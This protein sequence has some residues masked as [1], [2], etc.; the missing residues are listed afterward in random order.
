MLE[1]PAFLRTQEDFEV[2]VAEGFKGLSTVEKGRRFAAFASK[3]IA[4]LPEF[5]DFGEVRLSEKE[6]HD[7]G[8]DIESDLLEDGRRL[9]VQSK[10]RIAGKDD[11]DGIISKFHDFEA[12]ISKGPDQR[13]LFE[14]V[15]NRSLPVFGIVTLPR[16]DGIMRK[17]LGSFSAT[18]K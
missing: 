7:G 11:I 5:R 3:L 8:V 12:K 6:S 17:Y 10:L 4:F 9:C 15:E 14:S 16:S 1:H 13:G 2:H 18:R